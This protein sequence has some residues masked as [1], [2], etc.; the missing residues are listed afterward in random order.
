[1]AEG[2]NE[3]GDIVLCPSCQKIW[4]KGTKFCTQCGTWI[5]TGEVMEPKGGQPAPTASQPGDVPSQ[6]PSPPGIRPTG[7]PSQGPS[8]PGISPTLPGA[9]ASPPGGVPTQG[10]TPPGAT[11]PQ[12]LPPGYG[13]GGATRSAG[14]ATVEPGV[15][16]QG[17]GGRK[18]KFK[19][20]LA[21][22]E[23]LPTSPVFVPKREAKKRA[24]TKPGQVVLVIIALLAITYAVISL[25]FKPLHR[26]LVGTLFQTIGKSELAIKY[27]EKGAVGDS[28][29]A[30]KSQQ[31]MN[32]IGEK[33]FARHIELQYGSSWMANSTISI[34]PPTGK[35]G[36]FES[37]IKYEAPGTA[38][39][40]ITGAAT[41]GRILNGQRYAFSLAGAR[42]TLTFEQYAGLMRGLV[43]FGPDTLF[44]ASG[45]DKVVEA[46]FD[47]LE[48]ELSSVSG[49]GDEA[50]YEF[51]IRI[52]G[53]SADDDELQALSGPFFPWSAVLR[54]YGKGVG[55]VDLDIRAKDGFLERLEYRDESD[56]AVVIQEFKDFEPSGD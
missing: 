4:P 18:Y 49:S 55:R 10:P 8:P 37:K 21:R 38:Q 9:G 20:E 52:N 19:T 27:Y 5:E 25:A 24:G 14:D 50:V 39:E 53:D 29:W 56:T 17:E 30:D 41:G 48:I 11:P 13:P 34:T 44:D 6:G 7:V 51:V 28:T 33:I 3:A 54:M 35:H 40:Q 22:E 47:K 36:E 46:F 31:A 32:K 45:K 43:G 2:N 23:R 26:F 15:A 16:P 1:M 42:L 12:G